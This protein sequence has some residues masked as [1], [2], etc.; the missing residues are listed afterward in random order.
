V[1]YYRYSFK[2]KKRKGLTTLNHM[3]FKEVKGIL[4]K[5]NGMNLYRGCTHGCI[6]CDSRS[7][8][9]QI[10]HDFFDVEVKI[11]APQLLEEALIKKRKKCMI[12]TG[13]MGDPYTH[14]EIKL[15]LTRKCLEIVAK[16]QF[17]LAIQTKSKRI[18]RD[19]DLLK[20]INEQ[21]KCVVQMTLTTYDD[22][23]SKIIEPDVSTTQERIQVLNV[24]KAHHIPTIVWLSPLLPFINDDINN[25]K[26]ILNAC[27]EC[28]VK[29]IIWFGA[30][31]TLRKGN[32][33]Y[34]YQ[35]LDQH[36][37]GLKEKYIRLYGNQYEVKS[38][39]HHQLNAIFHEFCIK[40]QIM[41][42][43]DDIFTYLHTYEQSIQYEQLSIF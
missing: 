10:N 37:P 40:H 6:Y 25:L 3:H 32:R 22:E 24:M 29:G 5:H 11:N 33:E 34:F 38:P 13:S 16:H 31:L 26:K 18:L 28:S 17:G 14:D 35:K 12:G 19:L 20:K 1:I 23:L 42:Q 41:H 7:E 30:G 8:C 43:V 4:S 21:S 27:L 36:F 15:K 39:N 2:E 9:Y